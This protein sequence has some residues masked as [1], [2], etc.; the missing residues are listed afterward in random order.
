MAEFDRKEEVENSE[1]NVQEDI[2]Q[3]VDNQEEKE[4]EL[5]K[6]QREIDEMKSLA[7]RTQADFINYKRRVEKEKADL[8]TLSNEK[9]MLE[10]IEI[11]DNFERALTSEKESNDTPFYKGVG[12]IFKQLQDSLGKFG[13]QEIEALD[14]EF[15]PNI[16]HAVMQED[17]EKP[18]C[19]MEVLQKGYKL[20]NKVIRPAMVKVCK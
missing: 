20:K 7:Q 9:I 4:D 11:L 2:E 13:L 19:V 5:T 14:E 8:V 15:D 18:G 6:F 17:G 16:H 12:M 3:E 1:E 10:M